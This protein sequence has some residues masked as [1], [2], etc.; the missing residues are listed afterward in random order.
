MPESIADT[1]DDALSIIAGETSG[2]DI[3]EPL[4]TDASFKT[5]ATPIGGHP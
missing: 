5:A 2:L 4:A 3:D 1:G